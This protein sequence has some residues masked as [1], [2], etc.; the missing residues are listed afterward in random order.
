MYSS[1]SGSAPGHFRDSGIVPFKPERVLQRIPESYNWD[2]YNSDEE[3]ICDEEPLLLTPKKLQT[4]IGGGK[5]TSC[6][7]G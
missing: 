7:T 2:D 3:D 4:V 6:G 1:T 5:A